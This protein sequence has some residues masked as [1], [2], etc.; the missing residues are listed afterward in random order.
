MQ[1]LSAIHGGIKMGFLRKTF[2]RTREIVVARYRHATWS[3][4][5]I[6]NAFLQV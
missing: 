4:N 3:Q 5:P 1:P 2:K 6:K